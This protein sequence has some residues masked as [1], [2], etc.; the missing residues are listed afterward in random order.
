MP[1]EFDPLPS[2]EALKTFANGTFTFDYPADA[3]VAIFERG[4][5]PDAVRV[6]YDTPENRFRF[7]VERID[8]ATS[9]KEAAEQ[10]FESAA[11]FMR[12]NVEPFRLAVPLEAWRCRT[13]FVDGGSDPAVIDMAFFE[14]PDGIYR[15][16]L[17]CPPQLYGSVKW[18]FDLIARTLRP[19]P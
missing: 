3:R 1:I 9:A 6:V 5:L 11:L 15:L 14:F 19:V 7:N 18:V 13:R 4:E 16:S 12:G 17:F 2:E 10:S 8:A